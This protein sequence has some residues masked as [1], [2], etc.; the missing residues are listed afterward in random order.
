MVFKIGNR[1]V[2]VRKNFRVNGKKSADKNWML[3]AYDEM[4]ADSQGRKKRAQ[5]TMAIVP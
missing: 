4:S 3:T 1:I 5:Q 2:T